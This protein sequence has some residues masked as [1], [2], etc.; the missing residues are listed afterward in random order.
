MRLIDSHAHLDL[1]RGG[2][3]EI[4]AV[5][6]RAWAGGLVAVVA[7]AGAT[8]PGEFEDTL[9][10][11]ERDPRIRVCA[12]IHPHAASRATPDALERLRF[13][14]DREPVVGLGEIGLDYHY[15]RSP[16][17][18]QRRAFANQL[19]LARDAARPV[20]IHTREA[21]ADTLAILRDEGAAELGGVIHCFSGGWAL[22]TGALD[23]GFF[24]SFSGIVTFP[25]AGEVR[26]VAAGAPADRI[27][28]ETDAP[29]LSPVP[30]RGK[31]N[32]PARVVHVV[33]ELSR[34]RGEDFAA[35]AELTVENTRR[36]FRLSEF[37]E[38]R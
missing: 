25:N 32:E 26:E 18:D 15:D 12:G 6:E 35:T 1:A 28:A 3:P 17:S 7:V 27:L 36:C 38:D 33:E 9:R 8:R 22:A 20:A 37:C 13:A 34:L 4:R 31:V 14:L 19:R 21:D 23:L 10:L 11:A 29:F 5:L 2:E 16:P 24:L 30:H